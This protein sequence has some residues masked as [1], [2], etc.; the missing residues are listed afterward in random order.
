[1]TAEVAEIAFLARWAQLLPRSPMQVGAVHQSDAELFPIGDGRLLAVTIDTVAE[2]V[3]VGLYGDPQT[4]GR[5]A[6]TSSLSDLAAVGADPIGLLT[7]VTLPDEGREG[8]QCAIAEGL[9]RVCGAAGVTV[10]GGDT[11]SGPALAVSCVA[12][13]TV[14]AGEQLMRTGMRVGDRLFASGPL[15]LGA[16]LAASHFLRL[17]KAGLAEQDF[18]PRLRLAEGRALRTV[19]SACIDSSDG[20]VA[21]LDQLARL[22]GV[23]I[24]VG[25][26]AGLLHD[27]AQRVQRLTRLPDFPFLASH[28][29]EYELVFSVPE[30]R[31]GRLYQA[32]KAIGWE[33][34]EI[35]R[36][37]AGAGLSFAGKQVEGARVR[38]LYDAVGKDIGQY[39]REL[40][41][42]GQQA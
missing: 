17:G 11:N 36:A 7:S 5:M 39:V 38:N 23:E 42:L 19:A 20:L 41:S 37:A 12:I 6:A 4:V 29:G 15:G 32:S 33:P 16:A 40:C 3:A 25:S 2:E 21:A 26:T 18:D 24:E 35:G 10:L 27:E 1:M 30:D 34:V 31:I 8:L 14:P 28:H 13:G 22:N 9:A